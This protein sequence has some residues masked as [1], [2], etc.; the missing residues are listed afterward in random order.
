M[1]NLRVII[2]VRT[3]EAHG[4]RK[5]GFPPAA[6]RIPLVLFIYAGIKVARLA[7]RGVSG[8]PLSSGVFQLADELFVVHLI[9]MR[10]AI[11]ARVST[12][13]K[14]VNCTSATCGNKL[15]WRE[16]RSSKGHGGP[17]T[18]S[19]I[20]GGGHVDAARFEID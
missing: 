17:G 15:I 6:R 5:L 8:R 11:Y 7:T 10:V 12:K 20:P 4:Q 14:A 1:A 9:A 19:E 13:T 2:V 16:A 18:N 3:N